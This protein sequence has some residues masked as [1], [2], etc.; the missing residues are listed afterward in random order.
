MSL[1]QIVNNKWETDANVYLA[2]KGTK[3]SCK[4][5]VMLKIV[6]GFVYLQ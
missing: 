2:L 1:G 3:C 5:Y 4:N 6:D